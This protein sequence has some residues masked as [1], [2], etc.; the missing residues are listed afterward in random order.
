MSLSNAQRSQPHCV[1]SSKYF[2][3]SVAYKALMILFRN[4]LVDSE[5]SH[6]LLA[7]LALRK[8]HTIN[9]NLDIH[10]IQEVLDIIYC[11]FF[12][13]EAEMH[14]GYAKVHHIIQKNNFFSPLL[15][16]MV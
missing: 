13:C 1:V 9:V 7:T 2:E 12:H 15:H 16:F 11:D 6:S 8:D 10:T 14:L 3:K 5:H 4:N